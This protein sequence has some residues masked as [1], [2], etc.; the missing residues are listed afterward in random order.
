MIERSTDGKCKQ[1]Q[2]VVLSDYKKVLV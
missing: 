1:E 2:F